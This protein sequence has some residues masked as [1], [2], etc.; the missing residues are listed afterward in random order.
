MKLGVI[1]EMIKICY[2]KMIV[3][4]IVE[5]MK[6]FGFRK[7]KQITACSRGTSSICL[8]FNACITKIASS[9]YEDFTTVITTEEGEKY[10]LNTIGSFARCG[11]NRGDSKVKLSS[12]RGQVVMRLS[13]EYR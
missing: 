8:A 5:L 1:I 6:M 3:D 11:W 13:N 2:N 12:G 4:A 7:G 10:K 9:H